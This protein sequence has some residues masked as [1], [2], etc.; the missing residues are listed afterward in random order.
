MSYLKFIKNSKISLIQ[1]FE[2]QADFFKQG[3]VVVFVT[4]ETIPQ[5]IFITF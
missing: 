4:F 5:K 1:K 2:H 3:F